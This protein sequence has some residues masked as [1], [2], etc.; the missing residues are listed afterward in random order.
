[1]A[2]AV[3]CQEAERQREGAGGEEKEG[4]GGAGAQK[5]ITHVNTVNQTDKTGR[6]GRKPSWNK[7]CRKL[8]RR[9]LPP[10]AK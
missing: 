9:P 2:A 6:K 8:H 1:M 5:V 7:P 4:R 3:S 10:V